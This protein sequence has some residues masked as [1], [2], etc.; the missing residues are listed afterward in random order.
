M[1]ALY[2]R[3]GQVAAWLDRVAGEIVDLSGQHKAFVD[4][5]SVYDYSGNHVGWWQ[6]D[7][8][9]DGSGAVALFCRTAQNVGVYLPYLAYGPYQPYK[10]FSPFKPFKAF[11]PFRPYNRGAWASRDVI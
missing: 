6:D 4:G 11:K 10:A 3:N 7:H 1:D 9:R 8:I 5:D 2:N